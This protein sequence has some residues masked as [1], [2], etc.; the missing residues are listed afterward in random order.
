M[1]GQRRNALRAKGSTHIN[2]LKGNIVD[3]AW[4]AA[5][6]VEVFSS[7]ANHR[8]CKQ[9]NALGR[10]HNYLTKTVLVRLFPMTGFLVLVRNTVLQYAR[11]SRSH[12]MLADQSMG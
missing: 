8:S 11:F 4:R 2:E 7:S 1:T 3:P 12:E 9:C 6:H 10:I 5:V